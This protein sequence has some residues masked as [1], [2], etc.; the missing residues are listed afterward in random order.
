MDVRLKGLGESVLILFVTVA[1]NFLIGLA[2]WGLGFLI[3]Y[4]GLGAH[5]PL[6]GIILAC[7]IAAVLLALNYYSYQRIGSRVTTYEEAP[8]SFFEIFE[9]TEYDNLVASL[10]NSPTFRLSHYMLITAILLA[11]A[12]LALWLPNGAW[13]APVFLVFIWYIWLTRARSIKLTAAFYSGNS[14]VARGRAQDAVHTA[15]SILKVAPRSVKGRWLMGNALFALR[16][17]DGACQSYELAIRHNPSAAKFLLA[18]VGLCFQR[19]GLYQRAL[20]SYEEGLRLNPG[21]SEIHYG[22][23]CTYSLMNEPGRALPHLEHAVRQN[24][25]DRAYIE[26]DG[27]LDNI[28]NEPRFK[29]MVSRLP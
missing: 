21:A 2:V 27:D 8:R 10:R 29:E 9:R 18:F 5:G 28:R 12:V 14:L 24:Y 19:L 13:L 25:V 6:P 1:I 16:D 20:R 3:F 7:F 22:L 17:Y 15:R 23:G 4:H 11:A 26:K